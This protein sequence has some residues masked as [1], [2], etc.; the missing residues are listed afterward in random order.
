M[1]QHFRPLI[2]KFPHKRISFIQLCAESRIKS[3]QAKLSKERESESLAS[4]RHHKASVVPPPV[5]NPSSATKEF[6]S[7]GKFLRFIQAQNLTDCKYVQREVQH[8]ERKSF[9]TNI[10]QRKERCSR[11]VI[12]LT[13]SLC[14]KNY[15]IGC[16]LSN[17]AQG[18]VFLHTLPCLI[19][20]RQPHAENID[21]TPAKAQ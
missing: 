11:D 19:S 13:P 9:Q 15:L 10:F 5:I 20:G 12:Q 17:I 7:G 14:L 2:L 18:T 6:L 8:E 4:A 3:F 21:T 16:V 1:A